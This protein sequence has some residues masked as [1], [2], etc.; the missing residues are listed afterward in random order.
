MGIGARWAAAASLAAILAGTAVAQEVKLSPAVQ[1]AIAKP[2]DALDKALAADAALPPAASDRERLIR[3]GRIDQ[4]WRYYMNE[5]KLDG[6]TEAEIKAAYA[7][8]T[9]RTEPIDEGQLK[10]V[11]TMLPKEGWFSISAFGEEAAMA[12][13]HIV[14]H[15]DLATQKMV[16][17]QIE[18]MALR[19]E[20]EGR[21]FATMYDHVQVS[22]GKPQRYGTRFDC[23]DHHLAPYPL[24]DVS[25]VE[26]LRAALKFDGPSFAEQAKGLAERGRC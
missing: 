25:R 20:A 1:G 24:E 19:G 14:N 23:V 21:S 9:A 7:A 12:A 22:D 5:L 8:V 2:M 3:M 6:L 4:S 26:A 16:L 15:G 13:F 17:P 10:Q 18:A 11:M